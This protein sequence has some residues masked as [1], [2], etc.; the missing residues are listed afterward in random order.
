MRRVAICCALVC[1][2]LVAGGGLDTDTASAHQASHAAPSVDTG[3]TI[4][5]SGV[6]RR[7][8]S[9]VS[10][11]AA[12][13]E[14]RPLAICLHGDGG[15]MGISTAWRAAVLSD[16]GGAGETTIG[17]DGLKMLPAPWHI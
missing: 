4:E 5:I 15:N 1:G 6:T 12:P 17:A 11:A 13:A 3:G 9:A 2:L 16:S 14:G 7:F 10:A 8:V